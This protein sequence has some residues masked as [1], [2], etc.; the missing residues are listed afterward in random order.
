M[1]ENHV[2]KAA[3][4]LVGPLAEGSFERPSGPRR[5]HGPTHVSCYR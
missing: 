1:T 2:S 3:T 5:K 4:G